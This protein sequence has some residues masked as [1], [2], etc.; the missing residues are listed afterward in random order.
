M[1]VS[2]YAYRNRHRALRVSNAFFG[3]TPDTDREGIT[4]T[5]VVE[6][7]QNDPSY[8]KIFTL[9]RSQKREEHSRI[10][11][12]TLDLQASAEDM[13][14]QLSSLPDIDHVFFCA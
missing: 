5:A 7:L 10:K 13:S 2:E 1:T 4:G 12:A 3:L 11:H 8:T 9:S 6:A 14:K